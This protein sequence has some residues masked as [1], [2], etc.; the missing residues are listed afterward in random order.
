MIALMRWCI[1]YLLAYCSYLIDIVV[2]FC[3]TILSNIGN[4][5]VVEGIRRVQGIRIRRVEGIRSVEWIRRVQEIRRVQGIRRRSIVGST[6]VLQLATHFWGKS[7]ISNNSLFNLVVVACRISAS[8]AWNEASASFLME[9]SRDSTYR[10]HYH[11]R[12]CCR[13]PG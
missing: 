12:P 13:C 8:R 6:S 1:C 4:V 10:R 3:L 5:D 2:A 11:C 9:S 7:R